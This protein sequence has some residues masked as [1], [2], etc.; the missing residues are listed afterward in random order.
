MANYEVIVGNVGTV[1]RTKSVIEAV[2]AFSRY[3]AASKDGRGRCAGEN[4]VL[5]ADDEI[6]E[7]YEGF[8][9]HCRRCGQEIYGNPCSCTR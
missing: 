2:D 8:T 9:G 1:T 7:E 4:V 3:V 5:M 6:S